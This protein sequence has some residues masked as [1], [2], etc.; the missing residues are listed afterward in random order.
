VKND[1]DSW[2]AELGAMP[3]DRNLDGLEARITRDIA[4][5]RQQDRTLSAMAPARFIALGVAV[6]IG[7]VAGGAMA[8]AA[9]DTPAAGVF[10]VGTELAPSTLLAG[11]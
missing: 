1:L 5:L 3:P 7:A 8:V 10:A 2:M 11:V 9:L 4:R 6:A